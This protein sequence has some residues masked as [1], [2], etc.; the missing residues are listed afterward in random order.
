VVILE[1]RYLGM[2][3]QWQDLFYGKRRSHTYLG[4]V[5]DFVKYA[6]AFKAK[7]IAVEKPSEIRDALLEATKSDEPY[8]VEIKV[9]PE[10]HILPM[11]PPGGRLD[12]MIEKV[13]E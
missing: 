12:K 11:V 8:I 13:V 2:V 3:K 4:E 1:N 7:G 6:E 10:E 5:P 9:D